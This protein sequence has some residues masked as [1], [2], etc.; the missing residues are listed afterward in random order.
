MFHRY[1]HIQRIRRCSKWQRQF[2]CLACRR[3]PSVQR[4]HLNNFTW[5]KRSHRRHHPSKQSIIRLAS[6]PKFVRFTHS[7]SDLDLDL[8][9]DW[10]LLNI[11][12]KIRR[13]RWKTKQN[14]FYYTY[15]YLNIIH[16]YTECVHTHTH[17]QNNTKP[18]KNE[19][20]D[21]RQLLKTKLTANFYK[22]NSP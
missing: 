19:W 18:P 21:W 3:S 22:I 9:L 16:I 5:I 15:K 11:L 6:N 14:N 7:K 8:D 12:L 10:H 17:T 20:T 4:F 1:K 2:H 13:L